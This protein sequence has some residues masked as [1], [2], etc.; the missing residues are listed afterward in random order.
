MENGI[1]L[2]AMMNLMYLTEWAVRVWGADTCCNREG[3]GEIVVSGG[4]AHMDHWI[5]S[6]TG[7]SKHKGR[8]LELCWVSCWQHREATAGN[9][10]PHSLTLQGHTEEI[11]GLI[12]IF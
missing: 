12:S 7:E 5:I 3:D 1:L 8:P 2:N 9:W 10:D 6:R 4:Q 11:Q